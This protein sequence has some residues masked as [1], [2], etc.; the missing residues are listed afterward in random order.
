MTTL[1]QGYRGM[2][3]LVGLN[4]D[5]LITLA[6]LIAGLAVGTYLCHP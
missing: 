5:R 2:G 4:W 6:A 3:F 1:V